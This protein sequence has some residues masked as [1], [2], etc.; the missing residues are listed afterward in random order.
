[1]ESL[2]KFSAPERPFVAILGGAKL[3]E[4]LDALNALVK[5][6]D[7]VLIGGAMAYTLMKAQGI[8]IGKSLFEADKL[9]VANEIMANYSEKILLPIDHLVTGTFSKDSPYEHI[10]DRNVPVD[11][12]AIDIGTETIKNYVA[13]IANAKSI[14][15]NGPMGVFEWT[16]S[17]AGTR[18]VGSAIINNSSAFKLSGGGDSIAAINKF[19]L[20]GFDH[21]ST[22]GGAML[23]FISYDKFPILDVIINK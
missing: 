18:E 11:K 12:I 6:A 20:K 7:K 4:K 1:V 14:L 5:I 15:W 19:N 10:T 17:E 16:Q 8:E 9:E 22:G 2:G 23:A 13:E 3:S 21:V